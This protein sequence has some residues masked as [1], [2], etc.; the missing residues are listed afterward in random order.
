MPGASELIL[1]VAHLPSK[2]E[3]TDDDQ[4]EHALRISSRIRNVEHARKHTRT[5]VLGDFNMDPFERGMVQATGFH[6]VSCRKQASQMTRKIHDG[7]FPY[8]Y[9]PMWSR[10]GDLDGT[11]PGTHYYNKKGGYVLH[12]W[13]MFDQI[14]L[15]PDLIPGFD[16]Q[17]LQIIDHDGQQPLT[18]ASGRPDKRQF[19]DHLPVAFTITV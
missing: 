9:N 17:S 4:A 5:I 7:V 2:R 19:S 10:L 13:H 6:A 8:F 1:T 3:W 12:F 18:T 11:P 15:R 16:N 14:L